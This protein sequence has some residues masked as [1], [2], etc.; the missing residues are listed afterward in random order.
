MEVPSPES[1]W[2]TEGNISMRSRPVLTTHHYA[3]TPSLY[4]WGGALISGRSAGK[5]PA[6]PSGVLFGAVPS[7]I[8]PSASPPAPRRRR[9]VSRTRLLR[10][11][12][13]V[14]AAHDGLVVVECG[15]AYVALGRL[16]ARI[17]QDSCR[18]RASIERVGHARERRRPHGPRRAGSPCR[19]SRQGTAA[20]EP[21]VQIDV[22]KPRGV[23][24]DGHALHALLYG[25]LSSQL[26]NSSSILPTMCCVP[27]R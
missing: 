10:V 1:T 18:A 16:S 12:D 24:G 6:Q 19:K 3:P 15:R 5:T 21:V 2:P 13:R 11:A 7:L 8:Q 17:Y 26:M 4:R 23:I 25:N 20:V 14:V 9:G 27:A 22:G